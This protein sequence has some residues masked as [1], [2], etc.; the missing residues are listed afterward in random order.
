MISVCIATHNGEKYIKEQLM[1]ILSQLDRGDEVIISDDLSSDRTIQIIN[2]LNDSRIRI[3]YFNRKQKY[4]NIH[5][6]VSL[7]FENALKQ[8]RGDYIF[9]SDQ[10]DIWASNKIEIF[11]DYMGT[12]DLI[13]SDCCFIV[14]DIIRKDCSFYNNKSPYHNYLLLKAQY[15]G[16]CMAFSRK[17][18]LRSLPFPKNLALHDGWIGMIGEFTGEIKF[19][20]KPLTYYRIHEDNVSGFNKSPNSIYYK[21][22]YRIEIYLYLM[23]RFARILIKG[24]SV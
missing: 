20:N 11:R 13:I 4:K 8:T 17:V 21:I 15:H 3:F 22:M 16:C 18:L 7:N 14:N 10:D 12:C 24:H 23:M 19:I 9:L 2:S 5:E 1:S 6:L